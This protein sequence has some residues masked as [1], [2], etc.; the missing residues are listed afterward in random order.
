MFLTPPCNRI[1]G[2]LITQ[3]LAYCKCLP[4]VQKKETSM[5][6]RIRINMSEG[7][8]LTDLVID[9]GDGR[10]MVAESVYSDPFQTERTT[11]VSFRV[12][13]SRRTELKKRL[14][15]VQKEL[16]HLSNGIAHAREQRN[17]AHDRLRRQLQQ[18]ENTAKLRDKYRTELALEE[19]N[20]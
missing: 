14:D 11:A 13:P 16:D 19:L 3:G 1:G 10:E 7:E 20:G 12:V 8:A 6:K 5:S 15:E 18:Q 4:T 17:E 2:C 9:L